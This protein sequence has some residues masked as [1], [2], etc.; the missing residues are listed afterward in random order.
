MISHKMAAEVAQKVYD[1]ALIL[2][3]DDFEINDDFVSSN[4]RMKEIYNMNYKEIKTLPEEDFLLIDLLSF[5]IMHLNQIKLDYSSR[6]TFSKKMALKESLTILRSLI[7]NMEFHHQLLNMIFDKFYLD[8][9]LKRSLTRDD[10][11]R[12]NKMCSKYIKDFEIKDGDNPRNI[13]DARDSFSTLAQEYTES[14][15]KVIVLYNQLSQ[16]YEKKEF[17]NENNK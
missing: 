8:I 6:D 5:N 7:E 15:N 1:D 9:Q 2:N 10:V 13:L 4:M 11:R 16:Y 17:Y 3:Q 14:F 12:I